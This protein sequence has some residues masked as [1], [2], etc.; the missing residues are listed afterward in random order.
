MYLWDHRGG[1]YLDNSDLDSIILD[2]EMRSGPSDLKERCSEI[3]S[4]L[5]EEWVWHN[6]RDETQRQV[7]YEK[8]IWLKDNCWFSYRNYMHWFRDRVFQD[9]RTVYRRVRFFD[10]NKEVGRAVL[11]YP[12]GHRNH[13]SHPPFR[14]EGSG[15]DNKVGYQ[16]LGGD[17]IPIEEL[18]EYGTIK[19][20]YGKYLRLV[21][22]EGKFGKFLSLE[23]GETISDGNGKT[24]TRVKA[25]FSIPDEPDM[26]LKVAELL[27]AAQQDLTKV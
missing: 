21:Q 27:Q 10:G 13:H 2:G 5:M 22:K 25:W 4:Y 7:Y 1:I 26:P 24:D 16:I 18:Q 11:D 20:G 6:S 9:E 23:Q 14:A 19:Y 3:V 8:L 12:P 15:G 17:N